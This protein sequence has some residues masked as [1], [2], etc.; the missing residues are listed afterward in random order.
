MIMYTVGP[1][2]QAPGGVTLSNISSDG[3]TFSWSQIDLNCPTVQYQITNPDC[4]NCSLSGDRSATCSNL[5]LSTTETDCTFSV[6]SVICGFT[7]PSSN[8][9]TLTLKGITVKLLN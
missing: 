2:E 3:V 8:P 4:G 6:A 5:P 7:G 9:I 1:Y